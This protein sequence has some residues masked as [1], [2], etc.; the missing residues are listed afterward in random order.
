MKRLRDDDWQAPWGALPQE[1]VQDVFSFLFT[2][3]LASASMSCRAWRTA[4][5][6]M[7]T[8][9]TLPLNHPMLIAGPAP[10]WA[11]LVAN[12]VRQQGA[13]QRHKAGEQLPY[14][15]A[16]VSSHGMTPTRPVSGADSWPRL[17]EVTAIAGPSSSASPSTP[18]SS[19]AEG[20]RAPHTID[21]SPLAATPRRGT[22][23]PRLRTDF[24]RVTH[25]TLIHNAM[26]HRAQVHAAMSTLRALWPTLRGMS[27]HDSVTWDL[28]LDYSALG[29]MTHI[30]SLELL[31][32]GQGGMDEAGQPL[33]RASM[34]HLC[35]LGHLKELCMKWIIGYDVDSFLDFNEVYDLLASLVRHNQLRSLQFG[36]ENINA[37][38]ARHLASITTLE[39]LNL[40][41]DARPASPLHLLDLLTMPRL[42]RLELMHVC[43]DHAWNAAGEG[44][45]PLQEL[46]R[47]AAL[48]A[49]SPLRYLALS[50]SPGCQALVSRAL[51]LLPHLHSLSTAELGA[52]LI[53]CIGSLTGLTSLQLPRGLPSGEVTVYDTAAAAAAAGAAAAAPPLAA[54]KYVMSHLSS[55]GRLTCLRRLM[56]QMDSPADTAA[57][58]VDGSLVSVLTGLPHLESLHLSTWN[59]LGADPTE[60]ALGAFPERLPLLDSPSPSPSQPTHTHHL[61]HRQHLQSSHQQPQSQQQQQQLRLP[62][63]HL[64][65][66]ANGEAAAS[67]LGNQSH[68]QGQGAA[69]AAATEAALEPAGPIGPAARVDDGSSSGNAGG[70]S[71]ED[72]KAA[73]LEPRRS[74]RQAVPCLPELPTWAWSGLR[75]LS[76][77]HWPCVY[78][79]LRE[80]GPPQPGR[81]YAVRWDDLPRSLE[82][83]LL[84]RC[85]LVGTRPPARL[86]HMWLADCLSVDISI[87]KVLGQLPE[88]ETLVLRW[89]C[90]PEEPEVPSEA[91]ARSRAQLVAAVTSLKGLRTLGLGGIRCQDIP[92]LAPLSLVRHLMLE[93]VQP[94]RPAHDAP[95]SQR[96]LTLLDQLMALPLRALAGLRTLWLPNWAMPIKQ[97]LQWQ[98]MLQ[99]AMPLVVLRVTEYDVVWTVPTP[100]MHVAQVEAPSS[101]AGRQGSARAAVAG[102]AATQSGVRQPGWGSSERSPLHAGRG[103]DGQELE[104]WHIGCWSVQ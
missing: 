13:Q 98:Q 83:L 46:S 5:C 40:V 37:E 75:S 91:S 8:H 25:I 100:V 76:L 38:G 67:E 17:G 94:P 77:T 51:P 63:P 22:P 93:P 49:A 70:S 96:D 39:T 74:H 88:L 30:T 95:A 12:M 41:C 44:R 66:G 52:D 34:P 32:Q 102:G 23:L 48:L 43:P 68:G 28:P 99:A 53:A 73:L 56:I 42:T 64:Q 4:A 79:K 90:A 24:P 71:S 61:F 27:V 31:F 10:G 20:H 55:L 85:Q 45:D 101:L 2:H 86:R 14:S 7:V 104:W 19:T 97:L 21:A 26:L 89:P 87:P 16:A 15:T 50:L 36:G 1:L 58:F 47:R 3:D 18:P 6:A 59:L 9:L 82:A 60:E 72:R 81:C 69:G 92:S 11:E 78:G 29:V 62:H 103:L 80:A 84:V 33:Y 54:S 57:A 65:A 35:K